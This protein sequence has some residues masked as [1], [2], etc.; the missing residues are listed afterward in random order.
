MSY[1]YSKLFSSITASSIWVEPDET[2]IVWI[3]MLAMSDYHGRVFGAVPGLA[4]LARVSI[5]ATERALK[6]FLSP[7][8]YSRTK[9]F[10][11]RRIKEI[12]GGW[13]ILTYAKHRE[14][15]DSDARREYQ[16]T[17]AQRKRDEAKRLKEAT[18]LDGTKPK[19]FG[20]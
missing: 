20:K 6:C 3:T 9:E 5:P 10:E 12:D 1:T 7:D 16:K 19:K 13:F 15:Q 11:G 2:R 18:A 14:K 4:S 17:W 8:K